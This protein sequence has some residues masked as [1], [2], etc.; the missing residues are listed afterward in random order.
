MASVSCHASLHVAPVLLRGGEPSSGSFPTS[1]A[2]AIIITGKVSG[3][4][5]PKPRAS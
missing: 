4:Q 3:I 5:L 2:A 1:D